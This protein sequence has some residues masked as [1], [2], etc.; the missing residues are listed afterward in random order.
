MD[1]ET[2]HVRAMV[3]GRDFDDSHFNRAVQAQRQPGS[4]FKPFVYAAALEAGYTPATVIDHLDDPVATL[5]G[6]WT[7][8]DEHSS[9]DLDDAS[10]RR[11]ARRATAP[12]C[13]CCSRSASPR[14]VQYAKDMGVGDVP[15][16]PSLALGSGEVTLQAMTAAYAAFANHGSRAASRF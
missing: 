3:G 16:V 1:P 14:T 13:G 9:A 4:A 7:P 12:P 15:S 6:A 5:Q 11:C 10:H 8:E 2:G